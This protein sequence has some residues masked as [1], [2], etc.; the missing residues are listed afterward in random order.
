MMDDTD[1]IVAGVV[2]KDKIPLEEVVAVGM[3]LPHRTDAAAAVAVAGLGSAQNCQGKET[4][5]D[6]VQNIAPVA[7]VG[8]AVGKGSVFAFSGIE[9]RTMIRV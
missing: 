2:R 9:R 4:V 1:S 8:I 7:A 5:V 6:S 3:P